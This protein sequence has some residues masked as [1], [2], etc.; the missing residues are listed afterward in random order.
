MCTSGFNI[1]N[2][3]TNYITDPTDKDT[4]T[5]L[6]QMLYKIKKIFKR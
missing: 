5:E 6:W 3:I 1:T 4:Y 2:Y